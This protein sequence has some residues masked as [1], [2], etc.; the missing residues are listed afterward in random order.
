MD[1]SALPPYFPSMIK[2]EAFA[3]EHEWRI[4]ALDPPVGQMKFRSG[5]FNIRPFVEL[6]WLHNGKPRS[7]LPLAS[8]TFGPT[9]RP[10]DMPEEIIEWMLEKNGYTDVAV[11]PSDIPFRL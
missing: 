5:S 3:E 2:H 1:F 11:R 6:S 7:K 8:I 4:V 9:L 10:E